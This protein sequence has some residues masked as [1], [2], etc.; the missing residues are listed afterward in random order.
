MKKIKV[1]IEKLLQVGVKPHFQRSEVNAN[2]FSGKTV[3]VTG[4][5]EKYSRPEIERL[6]TDLG[7]NVSG[8]VSKKTDYILVGENAGSKLAKA[9]AIIAKGGTNLQILTE[10]EFERL[11][12]NN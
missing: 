4:T 5:L 6:L 11:A 7:A 9:Q 12:N 2:P 1:S 10:E 3:V 8:S